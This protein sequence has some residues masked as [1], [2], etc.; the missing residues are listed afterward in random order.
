MRSTLSRHGW[1]PANPSAQCVEATAKPVLRSGLLSERDRFGIHVGLIQLEI[2]RHIPG[3]VGERGTVAVTTL[4][5]AVVLHA[6]RASGED[7]EGFSQERFLALLRDLE[8][9]EN[10]RWSPS[11]AAIREA[12]SYVDGQSLGQFEPALSGLIAQDQR[13]F[14]NRNGNSRALRAGLMR[15]EHRGALHPR[16]RADLRAEIRQLPIGDHEVEELLETILSR[17]PN[18]RLFHAHGSVFLLGS[19]EIRDAIDWL[20]GSVIAPVREAREIELDEGWEESELMI[21]DGESLAEPRDS[22]GAFRRNM[23]DLRDRL[24]EDEPLAIVADNLDDL[25]SGRLS[26]K[27]LAARGAGDRERIGRALG[28]IKGKLDT[29]MGPN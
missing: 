16:H 15:S 22:M 14:F 3:L 8:L 7:L 5:Q 25:L 18:R 10:E 19:S 24:E 29:L 2:R 26:I 1:H 4:T 23:Q 12:G 20:A 27:D 17:E 9:W 11:L 28:V 6:L 13:G 21:S